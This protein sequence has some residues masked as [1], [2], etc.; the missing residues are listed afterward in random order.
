MSDDTTPLITRRS[1]HIR[2]ES[3]GTA[4][5]PGATRVLVDGVDMASLLR[6][7]TWQLGVGNH[8]R[9]TAV[10]E[11]V[12]GAEFKST[13]AAPSLESLERLAK[14]KPFT[15][16]KQAEWLTREGQL[17]TVVTDTESSTG[18]MRQC[19]S[20]DHPRGDRYRQWEVHD[21]CDVDL[22]IET[23]HETT[24]A[25]LVEAAALLP[26]LL[27]ERDRLIAANRDL[28]KRLAELGAPEREIGVRWPDER[29]AQCFLGY[30]ENEV[31]IRAERD[32]DDGVFIEREVRRTP[33]CVPNENDRQEDDL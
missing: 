26:G 28:T 31:R 29:G 7:V 27:D 20:P 17:R 6:S 11:L 1:P 15:L 3:D 32:G 5:F 10:L 22:L 33:W 19:S 25:F 8:G 12:D 23:W 13:A 21:C 30:S 9:A 18:V 2:I 16:R 14:L 24:A 4:G